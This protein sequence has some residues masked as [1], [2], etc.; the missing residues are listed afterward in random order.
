MLRLSQRSGLPSSR[1]ALAAEP[2]R[3]SAAAD[4]PA[5]AKGSVTATI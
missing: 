4:M 2:S 1:G 5:A 3:K